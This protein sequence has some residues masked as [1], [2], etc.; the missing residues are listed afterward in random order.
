MIIGATGAMRLRQVGIAAGTILFLI[1]ATTLF[2]LSVQ[3]AAV[4]LPVL[5][6]KFDQT[7]GC[8]RLVGTRP[9]TSTGGISSCTYRSGYVI[10]VMDLISKTAVYVVVQWTDG[11][12]DD[13]NLQR[14]SA[15][16]PDVLY[17]LHPRGQ[18]I[19][20]PHDRVTIQYWEGVKT[21][22]IINGHYYVTADNPDYEARTAWFSSALTGLVALV[23]IALTI[24]AI[25][26]LRRGGR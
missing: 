24:L 3:S 7:P 22:G 21:G 11:R 10:Q 5:A 16:V 13:I 8:G 25:R 9:P 26:D 17:F 14:D 18:P 20:R 1:V 23:S 19:V 4:S 15:A 12:S 2:V 6:R